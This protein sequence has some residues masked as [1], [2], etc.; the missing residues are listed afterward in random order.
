MK[1]FL[2]VFILIFNFNFL[3]LACD[4]KTSSSIE[5]S[6]ENSRLVIH[7]KVLS[8]E[9]ITYSETLLP[10]WS[11]SIV[12]WAKD[13][14]Q[15]LDLSTINPNVTRVKVLVIKAYKN[16]THLDTLT[17]FTPRSTAS[18]GFNEFESGKEFVIF[19]GSD[20]F[21]YSEFK[22]YINEHVQLNNTF[23]TDQCTRTAEANRQDLD[24]LDLIISPIR[25]LNPKIKMC[26]YYL[27]SLTNERI[28]TNADILPQFKSGQIDLMD[29]Y[30]ASV[31]LTPLTN[32]ISDKTFITQ[33]SFIIN[34]N[35][36]ISR[37]QF[38]KTEIKTYEKDLIQFIKKMPPWNPGKCGNN[39]ISF[40][41]VLNFRF[42]SIH[43]R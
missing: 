3:I 7:G 33:V 35:G 10:N 31:S 13:K 39:F 6:F 38:V 27:D 14:G 36:R 12:K 15:L 37:I 18:C 11:D 19:N 42:E 30:K 5:N 16:Q 25:V 1:R 21:K 20:L 29:F 9:F 8:K 2:F 28:Y 17:I 41:V 32:I 22:T 34:P 23:W 43:E 26:D 4:C 24:S 40:E